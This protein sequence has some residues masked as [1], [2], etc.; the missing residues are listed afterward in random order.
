MR[1]LIVEDNEEL[2]KITA[3][4]L[5]KQGFAVDLAFTG[6]EAIRTISEEDGVD[7]VVLDLGLPDIDGMKLI[8]KLKT[9]SGGLPVMAL[10]AR[11]GEDD[12]VRGIEEGFDDY[13][14]KPFSNVELGARIKVLCR[15]R[16]RGDKHVLKVGVVRL[17]LE[18]QKVLVGGEKVA[19]SLTEF[20]LLYY[21]LQHQGREV[22]QG[23]L[24]EAVWDR[25]MSVRSN[26]K[27]TTTI[28]RLR[29]KLGKK[30]QKIIKTCQG[31]Y[32]ADE[33]G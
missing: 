19:L 13:M 28:S 20:R 12:R 18:G 15:S 21:L 10:T 7:V 22:P 31:G 33:A 6:E 23:E 11:D 16:K 9:L 4:N 32:A 1:V 3:H 26:G 29:K 27:L 5:E 8:N 25:N 14:V 30:G 17:E 24:M 2:A